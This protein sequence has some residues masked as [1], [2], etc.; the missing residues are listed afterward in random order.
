MNPF[1]PKTSLSQISF[2]STNVRHGFRTNKR[3]DYFK[4]SAIVNL[5][6]DINIVIDA[7]TDKG[8]LEILREAVKSKKQ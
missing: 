5:R 3:G 1:K 7:I 8:G 2:S 4:L 6:C